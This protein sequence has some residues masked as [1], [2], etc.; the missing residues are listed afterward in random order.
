MTVGLRPSTASI[1]GAGRAVREVELGATPPLP[2]PRRGEASVRITGSDHPDRAAHVSLEGYDGPLAL[3][4]GLIEQRE[5]DILEVPLGDL[6]GAYLEALVALDAEQMGHIS[7]FVSVA[8]QLILIKSRA[9]LPRPRLVA[10]SIDEGPDPEEALRERLILYRRYRDAGRDLRGRLESGWEVFRREPSAAVASARAGSRPDEGP[11]LDASLLIEALDA[12]LRL[13]PPPPAA[14]GIVPRL[15]TLE[16]RAAIIR[17][18]LLDT[19]VLVLQELLGD[20]RDRVV[21]AV[22]FLAMLELVKGREVVVE[23]DEPFGPIVCR[24]LTR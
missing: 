2:H 8:S 11:P 1:A 23:Q 9:I 22:T 10:I 19:P 15:V 20:L 21:V 3:L 7:A 14:P 18:A 24:A 16:E 17:A 12:A 5:L 13:V 4:V 6:A